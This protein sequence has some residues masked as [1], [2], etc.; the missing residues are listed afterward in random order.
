MA[1][2]PKALIVGAGIGGLAA[3]IALRRGGWQVRVFERSSTARETGFALVLAPNAMTALRELGLSATVLGEGVPLGRVE[4]RRTDGHVLRRFRAP[5]EPKSRHWGSVVAL[6][7][8]LHGVLLDA[9]GPEIV[10]FGSEAVDFGATPVGIA[11]R[12]ADGKTDT[13]DVLIG[14]DGVGSVIRKRLHPREPPPHP[15][16][17]CALRGVAYDV[18]RYLADLSAVG[19]L[20]PGIEAATIRASENAVYWYVSMLTADV[21]FDPSDV[22]DF[23]QER[24]RSFDASFRAIANATGSEDVRFDWLFDRRPLH[25][26][27][28]V[29]SRCWAM[30]R[31]PC[32]RTPGKERHRHW[33]TPLP[34][35]W[36]SGVGRTA[37][38]ALH[39]GCPTRCTNRC[40]VAARV[41]EPSGI[42]QA[43]GPRRPAR[44]LP[45]G[46]EE[47]H[48]TISA[49]LSPMSRHSAAIVPT[50]AKSV[51]YCEA[52]GVDFLLDSTRFCTLLGL[53]LRRL[54]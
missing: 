52:P 39:R 20:G 19:Y 12:F 49:D 31:I 11:L 6:R 43:G 16:G 50:R 13:G 53:E 18:Q 44:G 42:Q 32:C 30:L 25:D 47:T 29:A 17:F 14:A 51:L 8:V 9:L 45:C 54:R 46:L 41:V 34:S 36:R 1:S 37:V 7:A 38:E 5:I 33:R 21:P 24:T 4:L 10:R 48:D 15:S 28:P 26:W 35:V 40:G 23:L 27:G 2:P 3:A 22:K